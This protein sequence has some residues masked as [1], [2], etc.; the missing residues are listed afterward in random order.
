M[1]PSSAFSKGAGNS[2]NSYY[3]F[4]SEAPDRRA[5]EELN[6]YI[7]QSFNEQPPKL[8]EIVREYPHLNRLAELLNDILDVAKEKQL[9]SYQADAIETGFRYLLSEFTSLKGTSQ[10]AEESISR[11]KRIVDYGKLLAQN[12]NDISIAKLQIIDL[13]KENSSL[14]AQISELK[15][16]VH[17]NLLESEKVYQQKNGMITK[18]KDKSNTFERELSYQKYSFRT[19]EN[20]L[21]IARDEIVVKNDEVEKLKDLLEDQNKSSEEL[22]RRNEELKEKLNKKSALISQL[23]KTIKEKDII[24]EETKI[25]NNVFEMNLSKEFMNRSRMAEDKNSAEM[26]KLYSCIKQ[27][28]L[29]VMRLQSENEEALRIIENNELKLEKCQR[30]I[31]E[32]S[33]E[34][35]ELT[36]KFEECRARY[37]EAE[38]RLVET[39]DVTT[40]KDEELSVFKDVV[41]R[42]IDSLAPNILVEKVEDI[43]KI[44][45]NLVASRVDPDA[46]R[47][48]TAM[49]DC[50][51]NFIVRLVRDNKCDLEFLK[52]DKP[53]VEDKK[54]RLDICGIVDDMRY[55]LESLSFSLPSDHVV[56][57]FIDGL[58]SDNKEQRLR[59]VDKDEVSL[60]YV[61]CALLERAREFTRHQVSELEEIRSVLPCFDCN[62]YELP[63]A[64]ATYIIQLQPVFNQLTRVT[65]NT[66]RYSG[67][68]KDIFGCLCTYVED[69]S[70]LINSLDT[71]IRP[72]I[73]YEGNMIQIADSI[74][75]YLTRYEEAL[76]GGSINESRKINQLKVE[77]DRQ[78]VSLERKIDELVDILEKKDQFIADLQSQVVM[79]EDR[80]NESQSETDNLKIQL[81][82]SE[83]TIKDLKSKIVLYQEK[84]ETARKERENSEKSLANLTQTDKQRIE[85]IIERERTTLTQEIER[86]Q[87]KHKKQMDIIE[88]HLSDTQKKLRKE[89][90]AAQ[91]YVSLYNE[92]I[93]RNRFL[94]NQNKIRAQENEL[95]LEHIQDTP[96]YKSRIDNLEASLADARIKNRRLMDE[97][98]KLQA[99]KLNPLNNINLNLG[100]IRD[101]GNRI[102]SPISPRSPSASSVH[103]NATDK[104]FV[105]ELGTA[106]QPFIKAEV[107]WT[108]HRILQ[109]VQALVKQIDKFEGRISLAPCPR[110]EK[111]EYRNWAEK[112]L[113]DFN[114]Q[115][116]DSLSDVEVREKLALLAYSARPTSRLVTMLQSL[117]EQKKYLERDLDRTSSDNVSKDIRAGGFFKSLWSIYVMLRLGKVM[118]HDQGPSCQRNR[119]VH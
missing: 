91:Y 94:E 4:A 62:P 80:Y 95:Q 7:K 101:S 68:L 86:E 63:S 42:V 90:E 5:C 83:T 82:A 93:E 39:V 51:A 16:E 79:N 34:N 113:A 105:E 37:G 13:E 64:V 49:A 27:Q 66:L 6:Q 75:Q 44:C 8:T 102:T 58:T 22:R 71:E 76:S 99:S 103:N 23:R 77:L 46:L 100:L 50:M 11:A 116:V 81:E 30:R 87:S 32:L 36:D 19:I 2:P 35:Q 73:H 3:K 92:A 118:I 60:C 72:L 117:R 20:E 56:T 12:P 54:K 119:S 107:Q 69:T 31:E 47:K 97:I 21:E 78:R 104:V 112:V 109:A 45:S 98:S 38:D 15:K 1:E 89:K 28:E 33:A 115:N 55:Y 26:R 53:I 70:R 106:L 110:K 17:S 40:R 114:T 41:N 43:P 74:K 14:R 52:L 111:I 57:E 88:K 108:K 10:M 48:I 65:T 96:E 67:D 59:T 25:Q 84:L 9:E 29:R 61:L 18:F 85:K 24:L